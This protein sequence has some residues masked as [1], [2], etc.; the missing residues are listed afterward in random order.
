MLPDNLQLLQ[1]GA[2]V[3]E[4]E[5]DEREGGGN[6][7]RGHVEAEQQRDE[8]A[9]GDGVDARLPQ[10]VLPLLVHGRLLLLRRVEAAVLLLL[11]RHSGGGAPPLVDPDAVQRL[12]LGG[13]TVG[14]DRRLTAVRLAAGRVGSPLRCCV[15]EVASRLGIRLQLGLLVDRGRRPAGGAG[16]RRG[17]QIGTSVDWGRR[18]AG[19]AG[20]RRGEQIGSG[21]DRGRR[22]EQIRGCSWVRDAA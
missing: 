4:V 16:R 15:T 8:H 1:A 2:D 9:Q 5:D 19:G 17:E 6:G 7:A 10:P 18:P 22:P 3:L 20:R 12:F 13:F 11:G 21:V 14:L